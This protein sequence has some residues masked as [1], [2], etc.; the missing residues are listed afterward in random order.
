M[1]LFRASVLAIACLLAACCGSG[2]SNTNHGA[3]ASCP[4]TN[5]VIDAGLDANIDASVP[6]CGCPVLQ[7]GDMFTVCGPSNGLR[8]II[9]PQGEMMY[10]PNS[11]NSDVFAS[12]RDSDEN[13]I[14]ITQ[15]CFDNLWVPVMYPGGVNYRPGTHVVK[16]VGN[17]FPQ[18]YVILPDNTLAPISAQVAAELCV[19]ADAGGVG[20]EPVEIADVFWPNFTRR[21]PEITVARVYP[22]LL[23]VIANGTTVYYTDT[24]GRFIHEVPNAAFELNHFQRRFVRRVPQSAVNGT[25][26]GA[27]MRIYEALVSDPAQGG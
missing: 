7:P 27:P 8:Y 14:T 19:P 22:G 9:D 6:V 5:P 21:A 1:N 13:L 15:P 17:N 12:W 24:N 3:D 25:F 23:F 4:N 10:F 26:I 18:L 20:C 16:R 2:T 11:T